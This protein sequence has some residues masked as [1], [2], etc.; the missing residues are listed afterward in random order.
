MCARVTD[1]RGV[2]LSRFEF[3]YDLTFAALLAHPDGRVYHR[4]GGRDARGAD[5]WL[6]EASFERFLEAGLERHARALEAADGD[7]PAPW[8]RRG[9]TLESVPAFAQRDRGE[10][11]HCHSVNTSLYE[12][13]LGRG[14]PPRDWSWRHPDPGRIGLDLDRDEQTLVTAVE[15]G[16][17]ADAAGLA[18]GDRL[19]SIDGSALC[20]ATDLMHALNRA[21]AGATRL[22]LRILRGASPAERTLA[23]ELRPGWKVGDPLDFAWR[24]LKWALT[25]A[26]GFGGA[27]LAAAE[28]RRLGLPAEAFA[29]RVDYLVT[30]GDNRRYGRAAEAAGIAL[31][32]VVVSLDGR[33]DFRSIEHVHAWWRLEVEAGQEVA[34]ELLRDGRARQV[35]LTAVP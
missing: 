3:D 22:E 11:I 24:P 28:M 17:P 32:D 35:R 30:W 15:P 2:D 34:I 27:A 10:C 31:G 7:R 4:Y 13:S 26:P 8:A 14:G 9:R 21:P 20:T 23:L 29:F 1:M 6:S 5:R 18:V 25:P 16:S 12:E 19:V 33:S